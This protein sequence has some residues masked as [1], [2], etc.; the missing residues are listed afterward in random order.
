MSWDLIEA[1]WKQVVGR[2]RQRW[3]KLTD[4]DLSTV[5]GRREKLAARIQERYG[6]ASHEADGEI[7]EWMRE[8]GVLDD[9]NDRRAILDM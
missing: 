5:E 7:E 4:D 9:W 3:D 1:N 2:V 6:I 8:P